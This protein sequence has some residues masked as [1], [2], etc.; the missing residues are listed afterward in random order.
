MQTFQARVDLGAMAMKGYSAFPKAP[1]SLE[2][3]PSDCLVSLPGHSLGGLTPLQRCS[4]CILQSQPT[5][6]PYS[7]YLIMRWGILLNRKQM[8]KNRKC[9]LCSNRDEM[10]SHIIS[11]CSKLAQ[12]ECKTRRDPLKIEQEIKIW[13]SCQMVYAKTRIFSSKWDANNSSEL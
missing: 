9:T 8:P 5:G 10:V 7:R 3:L 11:E 6:Q 2:T 12:R 13:R 4:R 1:A